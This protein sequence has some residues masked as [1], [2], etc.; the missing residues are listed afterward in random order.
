[1]GGQQVLLVHPG[2]YDDGNPLAFPPWGALTVGHALRAAGH[3]V[4]VLDL[5]GADLP[6]CL[7]AALAG[8]RPTVVGV[9]AKQGVGARRFRAVVDH[10]AAVA[11]G[12][13]V[14]AGGPLVSTFPDPDALI[15]RGVH[16]LVLGDGEQA[17][18]AWS[19]SRPRRGGLV[20]GVEPPDLDAVGVP[21]WWSGLP[22]YV[23]PARSWPNMAVPGIH[24][25]SARGC[26]RRCTFCYLNAQYPH[27]RFR[28]VTA[29]KLHDD[30]AELNSVTGARGFYFVD[31]CFIDT[32][33]RRVRDFC[34]RA[35]A[36][37]SPFRYG[38]DVQLS[39][40]DRY[41]DLLALMH[42]AG[43]RALYVGV[44]SASAETRRRLAKGTLRGGVAD[45]L[46]RAIDMGYVIRASIGIGW[47]GEARADAE[48]TLELI[49]S[50]PRL[51]FDAYRYYPLPHTPLGERSH[52][53]SARARLTPEALSATAFQDYSDHNDNHSAIPTRDY[54]ALWSQ[55]RQREDERL[56]AYFATEH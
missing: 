19:N 55:L 7:D 27:A 38:C 24:V 53:A 25:A 32:R 6:A 45:V 30:L 20:H 41:P 5:N 51:A 37:G 12:L 18:V 4:V 56:A 8:S 17:M 21:S 50:V 54:D 52:W 44:E 40:L 23:H 22:D 29:G 49:D 31:D 34:A 13:P 1:M 15:W 48:A 10:L 42:R 26:T 11:P 33:Q 3:D 28:Y 46:N 39:D 16:T 35:I 43:F 14:V 2:I 36:D 47:P 9:T